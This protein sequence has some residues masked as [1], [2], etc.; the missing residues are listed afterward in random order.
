MIA[1]T[2]IMINAHAYQG[3]RQKDNVHNTTN[4][5]SVR[6]GNT[7]ELVLLLDGVR[8]GRSLGGVGKLV[9]QTFRDGLDVVE[10]GFT[11]TNGQEGDGLVDPPEG[12]D[13]NG[14]TPDGSLGSDTGGVFTGTS[15]D[16]GVNKNLS[17]H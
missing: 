16:N 7:L 5:L 15:V 10:G 11:G 8:V 3:K 6:L 4:Q 1:Y 17:G 13:I 9:G 12:R 14:L 2:F